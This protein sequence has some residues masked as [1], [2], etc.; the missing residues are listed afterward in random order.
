[1]IQRTFSKAL[2]KIG[3]NEEERRK[4]N[5]TFHSWRHFFNTLCRVNN[6]SDSKLQRIT[7]HKT[8][9]MTEHYTHYSKNDFK[10]IL[11]VQEG[12]FVE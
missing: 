11:A 1:M 9:K 12:L 6:I 7:G 8:D 10:D 4:R 3:I 2:H 5:I